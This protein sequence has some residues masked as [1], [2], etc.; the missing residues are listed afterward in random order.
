MIEKLHLKK[1]TVFEDFEIELGKGVHVIIGENGTGKTHLLKAA[2]ASCSGNNSYVDQGYEIENQ[3]IESKL[4]ERLVRLFLPLD[5]KLGKLRTYGN[6]S[7]GNA[8]LEAH[9]S[10]T[11]RKLRVSFHSNS[12]NVAIQDRRDYER[13]SWKPVF[14]PT[15]EVI[16]FMKGFN[17]LYEKY[18]LSFDQSYQDLILALELPAVRPEKLKGK[19]ASVMDEIEKICGGKFIFQGSG[20]VTFKSADGEL[21]ANAMAEGF[22]KVGI[23]SRLLETGSIQPGVSGPLFWDEP[24]ANLNPKLMKWLVGALLELARLGQQVVIATHSYILLKWFDLLSKE[25]LEDRVIYHALAKSK[26][27]L[28]T[29]KSTSDYLAISPNPI[30]DTFGE[31]YSSE[32]DRQFGD[33]E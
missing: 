22:R 14:I 13:Y 1:F 12:Q 6:G 28:I 17:S 19:V 16:S 9:F 11:G 30:A 4:T 5:D 29:A 3:V 7:D 15:K 33:D 2:Y 21:S 24:E 18:E 10:P 26:D 31:L 20:K 8:E 27:G 25:E 23:V 32:I